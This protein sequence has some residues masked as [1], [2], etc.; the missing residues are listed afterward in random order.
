MNILFLSVYEIE[1]SNSGYIYADLVREF[2]KHHHKVFAI[3]PTRVGK[4][5]SYEDSNGVTIIKVKNGQI[6]KTGKL[7]KVINLLTLER[8]TIK[9]AKRFA[10]GVKFDLIVSMCSNLCLAKTASYFKKRD[11]AINYLLMKDIFPQ[12]AVDIGMM[13]TTGIMGI[14][15][16][17][18]RKREKR[19]CQN[20]DYI[21]CMS[22]ANVDYIAKHNPEVN[23]AKLT[24]VPNSIEPQDV[25]LS[26]AEK[27]AMRDK[28][29]IPQEKAV[30]VYGGNLGK[31]Q[32]IPFIIESLRSQKES[33]EV[34]FLIVGDGTEFNKLQDYVDTEKPSNVKL[35]QRLPREDFDRMLAACDVGMI[36]LDHRFTVP[37]Y[38]SRLLSY[39][40]A[41][42]PVLAC[43]DPNT[44]IGKDI[45][46]N[47]FGWW[48]ESN[49][50]NNFD[51]LIKQITE[52]DLIS[53]GQRAH[54][55]LIDEFTVS[56]SFNII[57]NE[58]N[59]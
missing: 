42:L 37:N 44:D 8:K 41:G 34:F 11:G 23:R 31:P 24:I 38:P 21:G 18:F 2:S 45:V 46:D 20:A 58:L 14:A 33:N 4:T 39:M 5:T 3:T 49:D 54:D 50:A 52:A 55:Y 12:N 51:N 13:K 16:R 22:N 28:Y 30:F 15:Y 43:T 53:M 19:M 36:F 7:K 32:D 6:Q 25:S 9:S 17:H 48:C 56:K 59:I 40:Q 26:D 1:D 10:K 27:V 29:G 57:I 35:M 47:E